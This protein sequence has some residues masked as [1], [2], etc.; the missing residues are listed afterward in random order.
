[1]KKSVLQAIILYFSFLILNS[2]Y[3]NAQQRIGITYYDVDHLYD[4]V[5]ALFYDDESYTPDGRLRWNTERYARKIRHTASVLDSMRMPLAALCGVENEAVVR[6]LVAAC[7]QDYCYV[8][9]TLNALDGMD[10]A[11]LYYGDLFFPDHVEAGRSYLYVEGQLHI[12]SARTSPHE[13]GTRPP[14]HRNERI[15][16]LLSDD[17]RFAAWALRDLREER[18]GVKMLVL[19]RSTTVDCARMGLDDATARAARAGRGNVRYRSGWTMRDR[20]LAD[21]AL[22]TA[23]GDVYARRYLFDKRGTRPLPT[24]EK[25]TYRCGYSYALPVFIYLR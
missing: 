23:G 20:I 13:A 5:P 7:G 11:L 9:R 19:G 21:T 8:H 4:T 12:P 16:L 2:S 17:T 3:S 15:G 24:Y 14:Q 10:F 25:E 22:R 6:D 18:P 1:M